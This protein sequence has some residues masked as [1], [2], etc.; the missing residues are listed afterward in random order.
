MSHSGES[1]KNFR[2]Q[3]R[4]IVRELGVLKRE[5]TSTGLTLTQSHALIALE[6]RGA[7]KVDQLTA[8]LNLSQ[9]TTSRLVQH[10]QKRGWAIVETAEHD[11]RERI[12][13]LTA[14]GK[15]QKYVADQESNQRV[16]KVFDKLSDEQKEHISSA[17]ALYAKVLQMLRQEC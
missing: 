5:Y 11:R 15:Q 13:N 4:T 8:L 14:E 7:M 9:S 2:A 10:F 3:M 12:V 1:I 17:L 6:E 16:A